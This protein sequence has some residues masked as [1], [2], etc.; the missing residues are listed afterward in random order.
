MSASPPISRERIR[1][2]FGEKTKKEAGNE[3]GSA[4]DIGRGP[5]DFLETAAFC[6]AGG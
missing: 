1:A 5:G 6:C 3:R 4:H 2:S